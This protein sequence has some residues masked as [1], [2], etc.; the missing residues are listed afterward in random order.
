MTTKEEKKSKGINL[1]RGEPSKISFQLKMKGVSPDAAEV[2]FILETKGYSVIFP[3]TFDKATNDKVVF[4]IPEWFSLPL[5]SYKGKLE[6]IV[7]GTKVFTPM[8]SIPVTIEKEESWNDVD[9]DEAE[10]EEEVIAEPRKPNNKDSIKTESSSSSSTKAQ[11]KNLLKGVL[12]DW[13]KI[14][15]ID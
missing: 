3:G 15:T 6:V 8:T 12:S 14:P 5:S 13:D 1:R 9:N 2:R 4:S 11:F 10:E 7:D